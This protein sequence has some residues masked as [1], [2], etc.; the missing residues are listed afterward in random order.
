MQ[1]GDRVIIW[2]ALQYFFLI[3]VV[4]YF[5]SLTL[6]Y[7]TAVGLLAHIG[8]ASTTMVDLVYKDGDG[9][10]CLGLFLVSAWFATNIS[11]GLILT[12]GSGSLSGFQQTVL[13]GAYCYSCVDACCTTLLAVW[14]DDVP[15]PFE[16]DAGD[17]V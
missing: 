2:Y 12:I 16:D 9:M 3:S 10:S 14:A 7:G 4:D 15:L 11:V 17:L 5:V 13:T 1:V 8:I 6:L